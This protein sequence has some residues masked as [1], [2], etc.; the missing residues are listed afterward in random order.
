MTYGVDPSAAGYAIGRLANG[1]TFEKFGLRF[2]AATQGYKF[3][4][5]AGIHDRGIDGLEHTFTAEGVERTVYQISIESNGRQ[6]IRDTLRALRENG[7]GAARLFY[8]TNRAISEKDKLVDDMFRE[9][10][11]SITIW[12]IGWFQSNVN[13]SNATVSAY[14]TLIDTEFH[15]FNRPGTGYVIANVDSDPRLFIF[16]RQTL[17]E[18]DA[19]TPLLEVLVDSLILFSLEGTDPEA[20]VL[21]SRQD[22]LEFAR[23][24]LA[25]DASIIESRIDT[26]LA[27]LSSKP[28][29][30]IRA[31]Q[32]E[33]MYSL[34][35]ETR[36][37]IQRRNLDDAA[38][39]DQF[40]ADT[41]V[42]AKDVKVSPDI[43]DAVCLDMSEKVLHAIFSEQGLEFTE[44]INSKDA[45]YSIEKSLPDI[46]SRIV[47]ESVKSSNPIA[48][49]R[50]VLGVIR[51]MVYSGSVAQTTFLARLCRTYTMLFLLRCDP[52]LVSFFEIYLNDTTVFV[53][54]SILVPALSEQFLEKP[55]QRYANLLRGA[56]EAGVKLIVNE[57]AVKELV[58]HFRMI[59]RRYR[60]QYESDQELYDQED[61]ILYI[62][63]IMIRAYFYARRRGQVKAFE[64]FIGRF[65]SP[66]LSAA[67][68]EIIP[69]LREE[70]GVEFRSEKSMGVS[71]DRGEL[72]KLAS[73]LGKR[74]EAP[75]AKADATL[76]LTIY[77]LRARNNEQ[78]KGV[79]GYKTWWLSTD[80]RTAE[81][82]RSV[83][84][85]TY[86]TSCYMRADF[87]HHLVAL[88]PNKTSTEKTFARMFPSL[89]GVSLSYHFPAEAAGA[90]REYL[91]QHRGLNAAR[92][93]GLLNSL[94]N[95]LKSEGT[96]MSGVEIK[97]FLDEERA[98][99]EGGVAV[100]TPKKKRH[101]RSHRSNP[102]E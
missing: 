91:R 102:R 67:R 40:R 38:L 52:K 54:T 82:V 51:E 85:Q 84:G 73:E 10:D 55:H 35:F 42:S 26:R 7:I 34:P 62:Q 80:T 81:S 69:W 12:D 14:Q 93:K 3:I 66:D 75:R 64:E 6:K 76:V 45:A 99:L 4:P 47:D 94:S 56:S 2:L 17:D 79:L 87:L 95:K 33:Q 98:H 101:R 5:V 49:K 18:A 70:Y 61:Q 15:Q 59:M 20:N 71:V 41:L 32:K 28:N 57:Q 16:L 25:F 100:G 23:A 53:D 74:K 44:F 19:S 24:N 37:D 90:A 48:L 9:F 92:R 72:E 31:Y 97:H 11:I 65:V 46:V 1:L 96:S 68:D 43:A 8:V 60:D 86:P 27:V 36:Q 77:A 13:A 63:E 39:Y 58:S 50:S 21:R 83:L 29:R 89:A 88:A 78:A 30:R 22:I